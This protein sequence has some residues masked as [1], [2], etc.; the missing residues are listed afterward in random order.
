MSV[1]IFAAALVGA[2]LATAAPLAA[3]AQE[4]ASV[5]A[6]AQV[7]A[8]PPDGAYGEDCAPPL[9]LLAD[10]LEMIRETYTGTRLRL[11]L[12]AALSVQETAIGITP[13]QQQAWRAYTNALLAMVPEREPVVALVGAGD[14]KDDLK[15]PAAFGRADALADLLIASAAKAEALKGA[16]ANLRG[17]LTAQQLEAARIPRLQP[18]LAGL[19]PF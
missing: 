18:G 12:A 14:G 4:T 7:A 6:P 11:V 10:R 8:V 15:G 19:A 3:L 1:R 16:V 13:E 2:S 9:A 17:K 5:R